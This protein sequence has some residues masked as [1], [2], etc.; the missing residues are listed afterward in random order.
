MIITVCTYLS[1]FSLTANVTCVVYLRIFAFVVQDNLGDRRIRHD[2]DVLL[3]GDDECPVSA[4]PGA[5]V[6]R[7]RNRVPERLVLQPLAV[8]VT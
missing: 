6:E 8:D 7:Q 5:V 2:L 1:Q 3:H 4:T